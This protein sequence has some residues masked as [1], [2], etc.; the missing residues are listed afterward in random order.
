MFENVLWGQ[1]CKKSMWSLVLSRHYQLAVHECQI[2]FH[3]SV[4]EVL[5]HLN[6]NLVYKGYQFFHD[7][8]LC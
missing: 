2:I 6:L 7:G 5:L 1:L 3:Y 8:M 4:K